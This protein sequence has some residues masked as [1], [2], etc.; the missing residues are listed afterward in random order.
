MAETSKANNPAPVD[1]PDESKNASI[2]VRTLWPHSS[3]IV[4]GAPEITDLGTKLTKSQ[5]ELVQ[6]AA[7]PSGVEIE[8]VK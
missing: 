3:F 5:F 8:E 2:T 4:E 1:L 6:R 7:G